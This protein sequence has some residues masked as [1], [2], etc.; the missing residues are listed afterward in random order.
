[1]KIWWT[2]NSPGTEVALQVSTTGVEVL[3]DVG[4]HES[5]FFC[6]ELVETG[7]VLFSNKWPWKH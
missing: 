3:L 4:V 7:D 5:A 2:Q 1:M 6:K